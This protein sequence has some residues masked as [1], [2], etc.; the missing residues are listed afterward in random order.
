MSTKDS[1]NFVVVFFLVTAVLG[2]FSIVGAFVY[3]TFLDRPVSTAF[4]NIAGQAI[5]FF[6]AIG[7]TM[8]KDWLAKLPGPAP[9]Q[10]PAAPEKKG[11]PVP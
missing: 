1:V 6:V 2:C 11:V 8:V 7:G 5:G 10:A 3:L 9:T 4:A